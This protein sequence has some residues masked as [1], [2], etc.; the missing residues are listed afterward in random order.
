MTRLSTF[1]GH[2]K[3]WTY[4][5]DQNAIRRRRPS[6]R[7]CKGSICVPYTVRLL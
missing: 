7:A 2:L 5:H 3:Y 4:I 6:V 1:M